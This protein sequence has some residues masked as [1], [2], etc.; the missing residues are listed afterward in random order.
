MLTVR[1]PR[2]PGDLRAM[3][4]ERVQLRRDEVGGLDHYRAPAEHSCHGIDE[5]SQSM[6]RLERPGAPHPHRILKEGTRPGSGHCAPCR[7]PDRRVVGMRFIGARGEDVVGLELINQVAE[8]SNQA[9]LMNR[10]GSVFD[11]EPSHRAG[12]QPEPLGGDPHLVAPNLSELVRAHRGAPVRMPAVRDD[13]DHDAH[14]GRA[15]AENGRAAT[16]RFIVGVWG[17]DQRRSARRLSGDV[18]CPPDNGGTGEPA[19]ASDDG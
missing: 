9:V 1:N 8:E 4:I 17:D 16:E 7:P 19:D 10:D 6:A 11:V 18:A 12:F 14:P 15:P 3:G 13:H 2:R 5:G